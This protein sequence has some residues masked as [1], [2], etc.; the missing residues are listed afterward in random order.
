MSLKARFYKSYRR[1]SSFDQVLS[2]RNPS[3]GVDKPIAN[4]SRI[5]PSFLDKNFLL[6]IRRVG[7]FQILVQPSFQNVSLLFGII[8]SLS[9]VFEAVMIGIIINFRWLNRSHFSRVFDS[10]GFRKKIEMSKLIHRSISRHL[11]LCSFLIHKC[12]KFVLIICLLYERTR[13]KIKSNRI[14]WCIDSRNLRQALKSPM[15]KVLLH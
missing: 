12:E 4:L 1:F 15:G 3:S 10:S 13:S 9:T 14:F 8:L 11:L 5:K 2:P 6:L 7:I